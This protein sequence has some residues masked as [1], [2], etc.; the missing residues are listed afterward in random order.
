MKEKILNRFIRYCK[1]NTKSN[2]NSENLPSTEVQFELAH[3]LKNELEMLG[4]QNVELDDKCYLMAT[5]PANTSKKA[6][7]IGFISHLDTAPDFSGEEVNPQIIENYNGLAIKLGNSGDSIDPLDFPEV[8]DYIGQTLITTD[9]KTLLGADDKAG[10]AE[11]LEFLSYLKEHPEL[12]HGEIK[13]GFTPD[14]EI[15]RGADFFDVSKFG[16]EFAYTVDGGKI[17]EIEY[18]TFNAAGAKIEIHGRNVHPGSAKGKLVSS[19]AIGEELNR[20]LPFSERPEYT[21]GYDGFYFL[22]RFDG[23]IETTTLEYIIR[24]HSKKKFES[25]KKYLE[26]IVAF[27]NEKFE[28]RLTLEMKDQYYNMAEMIKP[29]PHIYD[30]AVR[31]IQKAGI[32]P[33]TKPVR[34]GTDGSKLSFM[35]LPTPN[36]F[37]G[38]HNGHGKYE[39]IPVESMVKAVEVLVNIATLAVE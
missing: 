1:V 35:G 38:G 30:L 16:A 12:E 21:E 36:I 23:S 32:E 8:L 20:M 22:M 3:I 25:R 28:N 19:I 13:V 27:L 29:H 18:E 9:G 11:I 34:G 17:G 31:A 7:T 37:C 33:I 24:D 10:I 14:E 15:G 2:P 5:L 39:F 6:P 4:L 26:K